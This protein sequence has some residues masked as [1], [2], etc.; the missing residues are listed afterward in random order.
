M[1]C[2]VESRLERKTRFA[3]T[4]IELLVVIAIIAILASMLLPALNKG[5]IA[6][7]EVLSKNNLKQWYLCTATYADD[8]DGFFCKGT[9]NPPNE[10]RNWRRVVYEHH[11]SMSFGTDSAAV[12]AA[13]AA[14]TAWMGMSHCPILTD[15]VG[16]PLDT[17]VQ[18]RGHYSVNRY[19]NGD[20]RP[21]TGGNIEPFIVGGVPVGGVGT[22]KNYSK[23]TF[24]RS[25]YDPLSNRRIAYRYGG[26]YQALAIFLDGHVTNFSKGE[27]L[28]IDPYVEDTDTFE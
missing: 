20:Y 1:F 28:A 12:N 27:G 7:K 6:A 19:F 5:K 23:A 17:Q 24:A 15:I 13:M 11:F 4:L 22:D 9:N 16:T 26:G 10:D 25:I 2:A 21:F 3:F 18:G 8:H 14:D